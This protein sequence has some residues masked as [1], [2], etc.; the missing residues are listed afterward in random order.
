VSVCPTS[1]AS[2]H[3]QRRRT[4]SDWDEQTGPRLHHDDPD[5]QT[6]TDRHTYRETDRQTDRE[7]DARL[8]HGE[9][10]TQ[11]HTDI[12]TETDR[13]TPDFIM[14]TLT[15]RHTYRETDRP[16]TSSW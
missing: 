12:H 7:T 9:P 8:H 15:H 14:M 4:G 6:H 2:C 3:N 13:Q 5:T 1:T 10:D 16:Q 11:T